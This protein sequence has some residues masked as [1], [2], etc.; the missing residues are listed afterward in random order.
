VSHP[1]LL[2]FDILV[3]LGRYADAAGRARGWLR[4]WHNGESRATLVRSLFRSGAEPE[5]LQLA[6]E[7]DGS[8]ETAVLDL[9]LYVLVEEG[10]IHLLPELIGRWVTQ[11]AA[12]PPDRVDRH[13]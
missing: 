11:A 12:L 4:H 5:A 7:A 6:S 3:E 10:R 9:L 2:L 8:A 13:L 1:R